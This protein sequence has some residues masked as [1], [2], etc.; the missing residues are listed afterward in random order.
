[1]THFPIVIPHSSIKKLYA[2]M[3]YLRR[4][5]KTNLTKPVEYYSTI[6]SSLLIEPINKIGYERDPPV[7]DGRSYKNRPIEMGL[8]QER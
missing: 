1:M 6:Y 3:N 8:E 2:L 7:G 5:S 4:L